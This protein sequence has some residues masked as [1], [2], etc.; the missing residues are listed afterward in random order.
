MCDPGGCF[1]LPNLGTTEV[2]PKT[3]QS[4]A[5]AQTSYSPQT[6]EFIAF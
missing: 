1:K 6:N 5:E 3:I 4:H 2:K